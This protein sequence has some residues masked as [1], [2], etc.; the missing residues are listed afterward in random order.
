MTISL[1]ALGR[2]FKL[3][4]DLDSALLR[5]PQF[6]VH[7]LIKVR[8]LPR[9]QGLEAQ[10]HLLKFMAAWYLGHRLVLPSWHLD[11]L[12]LPDLSRRRL[13]LEIKQQQQISNPTSTP[14]ALLVLEHPLLPQRMIFVVTF[15][16]TSVR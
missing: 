11:Y 2:C 16:L 15:I 7:H 14:R 4:Q 10:L 9:L 8:I 6:E 5:H 13:D 3:R 12:L 1:I